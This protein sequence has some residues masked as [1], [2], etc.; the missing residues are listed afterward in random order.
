[1]IDTSGWKEFRIGDLFS[2]ILSKGDIKADAVGEGNVPLIS[3]GQSDNGLV[4]YIDEKGD[5]K[6]SMFCGN[7]ITVDMFCNA[8]Y[9]PN[10]YYAVSHGRIN[11]L[12]PKFNL[13]PNIGLFICTIIN[14]E[15]YKYSYGRAVYSNEIQRM[16]IKLPSTS[17]GE[18]DWQYMEEFMGGLHCEPITTSVQ[19][20]HLPL[21]AEKW[22]EFRVGD[23]FEKPYKALA[24]TKEDFDWEETL[25]DCS[26]PYV[27]RTES[28]N[29]VDGYAVNKGNILGIESGNAIAIGDTTSTISYQE[30]EFV[31]GD[32]IVVLRADWLNKWTGL[33]I[34]TILQRERYR[35]SYG[36]AFVMSLIENTIIRLPIALDGSPDWQ[37]MEDYMKSLPYSDRIA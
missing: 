34:T 9:Q 1:M 25:T 3:S 7:T 2:V 33:F 37:W 5:G 12:L 11:V 30:N 21:E 16:I 15:T 28:N 17:S 6:A 31:C 35:Y 26:L 13:T 10:D 18:P 20:S 23:L 22:G 24:H 29:A 14:K 19:S 8:F 27:S 32:H 36:R 4:A